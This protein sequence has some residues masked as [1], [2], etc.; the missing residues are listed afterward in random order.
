MKVLPMKQVACSAPSCVN[1]HRITIWVLEDDAGP[2]FCTD[3]CSEIY[4][5]IEKVTNEAS[6]N[7]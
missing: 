5:P 6:S 7:V 2:W 3:E 4:I 1:D